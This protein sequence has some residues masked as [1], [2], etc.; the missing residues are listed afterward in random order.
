[1][2]TRGHEP[3]Q[4]FSFQSIMPPPCALVVAKAVETE[5]GESI[6]GRG[7][8][9]PRNPRQSQPASHNE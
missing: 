1:M 4:A 2:H 7:R 6:H 5:L 9:R 3:D 8:M